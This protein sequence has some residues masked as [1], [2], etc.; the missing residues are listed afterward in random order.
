MVTVYPYD[1]KELLS[2]IA[3]GD[4]QAFELILKEYYPRLRPF[5]SKNTSSSIDVEEVLQNCFLRVWINRDKLPSI[6]HFKAWIYKVASR[7]Y[8]LYLRQKIKEKQEIPLQLAESMADGAGNP[9]EIVQMQQV[10]AALKEAVELL[11][12]QRKKIFKM[13]RDE[14]MKVAEIA[15]A[16]S[17]SSNTVK[18]ALTTALK[19]IRE[20]LSARGYHIPLILLGMMLA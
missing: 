4:E 13:S 18:N 7:E 9:E 14:G 16:L 17:L 6:I 19:Q 8:L 10:K 1:E 15:I 3:E 5:I 20:Y 12:E 2:R 11:P